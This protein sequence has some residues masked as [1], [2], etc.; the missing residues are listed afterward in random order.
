MHGARAGH[1]LINWHR[2]LSRARWCLLAVPLAWG[3]VVYEQWGYVPPEA[4]MGR[5]ADVYYLAAESIRE[6]GTPYDPLPPPGPHRYGPRWYLYPPPLAAALSLAHLDRASTYTLMVTLGAAACLLFGWAAARLAGW[7]T[8]WPMLLVSGVLLV[9][10]GSLELVVTGNMQAL[11]DALVMSALVLPGTAAAVLLVL[12]ASLKVTPF[13]AA[14]IVM[15]RGG[16]KALVAG[17]LAVAIVLVITIAALGFHGSLTA[18]R[19]WL[20]QVAPTLSQGQFDSDGGWA[21]WNFSP[22]FAPVMF[23]VEHP[24][25]GESIPTGARV[26]LTAMQLLVPLLT[27]W[28]TRRLPWREQAAWVVVAATLSAPILRL[29]YMPILLIAPALWWRRVRERTS[30]RVGLD[31]APT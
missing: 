27:I 19:V 10:P 6:H 13:W 23:L 18:S 2:V 30:D 21:Y 28:I 16:S 25:V 11:V 3:A 1:S 17:V 15:V 26:Y 24:P 5:D 31:H 12:A 14:A 20:T 29:G 4:W 7:S 9:F 22:V 8:I